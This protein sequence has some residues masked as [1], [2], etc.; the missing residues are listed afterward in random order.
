MPLRPAYG[1]SK[2]GVI[3]LTKQLAVE[4]ASAGI[5]V[6][7]IC[8]GGTETSMLIEAAKA[9]G[10]DPKKALSAA[11]KAHPLGRLGRPEEMAHAAVYLAS[12]LS[13]F[14]TGTILNV[15]GGISAS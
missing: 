15:D 6:N 8:P 13:G 11:A 12:E 4:Y 9:Q 10:R 14:V 2:A 5:R 7:C 1:A 3:A